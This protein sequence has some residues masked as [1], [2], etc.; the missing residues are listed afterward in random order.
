MTEYPREEI[1]A[2]F[3]EFR[4]RGVETHDW[5]AW[6][7][8]FTEDALYE[9][10]NL[11]VFHGRAEIERWI[12]DCMADYPSMTLWIE[13]YAIDGNR[14]SFY[15]WNNL[16]DPTGTGQRFGFPNTTFLEYAGDGK[17]SF[18]GDYYNPEDAGRVFGEWLKAGGRRSTPQDRS[19][20]GI[21]GWSPPVP[22][23][24]FP[25]DE[26]EAEF[27]KYRERGSIAVATGDWNQWADQFTDDAEYREHH[28]GYFKGQQEIRD[29]INGVMQPFPTMEFP[30]SY[31]T[32]DGNRVSALIPNILPAPEGDDGYYGFDVNT[33]LHYAGNGKWSYEEDVYSPAEAQDVISRWLAAGGV[34]PK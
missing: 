27:A 28:Y 11:G 17:F 6:A 21:D 30:V 1:E 10:H 15:I 20:Q 22:E 31:F 14:I 32:V 23:P 13:W 8:L 2:A 18:E 9:E 12:V 25:R 26:I 7:Q 4:R 33:I 5:P 24:A 3:A 19:L 34:I 16:P 29:W